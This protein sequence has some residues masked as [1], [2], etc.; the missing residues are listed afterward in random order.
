MSFLLIGWAIWFSFSS[1]YFSWTNDGQYLALGLANGVISLRNKNGDDTKVK[2][3][4]PGSSSAMPVWALQWSPA[5]D[6]SHDILAVADWNRKLSFYRLNGTAVCKDADIK[7]DPLFLKFFASN[8][9]I[10]CG[11]S[12]KTAH[13]F[14]KEGKELGVICDSRTPNVLVDSWITCCAPHPEE[15]EVV[16]G[17][18]NGKVAKMSITFSTVHGLYRERYVYRVGVTDVIVQHLLTSDKV[19]IRCKELIKKVAVYKNKL[20]IQ[21][22]SRILIYELNEADSM[23][24]RIHSMIHMNL[25]CN[26]LVVTCEHVILCMESKLQSITFDGVTER[27]W[28]LDSTIRYIKVIGGA[29]GREGLLVALSSGQVLL[30]YIDNP[31]PISVLKHSL[32]IRCLDMSSKRKKIAIVDDESMCLVF[33]VKTKELLYQEQNANSVAWN[34]HNEEMLCFSGK[35]TLNIKASTFPAHQQ[36]MSGYVVGFC[37]SN[38]FCLGAASTMTSVEVPQSAAMYQYLERKEFRSAYEVACLGVTD[39]DWTNLGKQAMDALQLEIAKQSFKKTRNLTM[40]ELI[41]SIEE[42]SKRN[43][44]VEPNNQMLYQ[45]DISAYRG[46]FSGAAKMYRKSGQDNRAASMYT[47]LRMFKEA[48]EFMGD[49][50]E[51]EKKELISKQAEWAKVTND[52]LTAA[53]MFWEAGQRLK[54]L[55]IYGESRNYTELQNKLVFLDKADKN[56]LKLCAKYFKEGGQLAYAAEAYQ[57]LGDKKGYNIFLKSYKRTFCFLVL[58]Q[59]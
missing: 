57:K 49:S 59:H 40:L 16:I 39:T 29:K 3:E 9:F 4:R 5:K 15:N 36:K 52:A 33:D 37:G 44:I 17:T 6:E 20:A 30:V 32:P 22:N 42:R 27:E 46:E 53:T 1:K 28:V 18:A 55:E 51:K 14:T 50:T 41:H 23:T 24:Y 43:P 19:R 2:I 58:Q 31:F 47:D 38:V 25:D 11:G 13:L 34:T 35:D 7:F 12:D 26:L 10:V 21:L 8:D 45:A 56:E 48:Q 54:A